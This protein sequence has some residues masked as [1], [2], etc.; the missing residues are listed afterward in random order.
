MKFTNTDCVG[1]VVSCELDSQVEGQ[2]YH[3]EWWWRVH[4]YFFSFTFCKKEIV[5]Y[6]IKKTFL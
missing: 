3:W 6:Y 2:M 4:N 5:V 1:K